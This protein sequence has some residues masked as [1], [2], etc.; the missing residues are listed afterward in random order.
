M[1]DYA[2]WAESDQSPEAQLNSAVRRLLLEASAFGLPESDISNADSMLRHQE[3]GCA[4]DI[5]AERLHEQN[6]AINAAYYQQLQTVAAKMQL[7]EQHFLF[8]KELIK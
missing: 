8:V 6:I 3:Y 5:I 7:P 2:R 1:S 4:C